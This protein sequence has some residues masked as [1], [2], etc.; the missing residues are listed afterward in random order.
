MHEFTMTQ[1]DLK[2][3][4]FIISDAAKTYS[5][6]AV[7]A[8]FKL[9]D[10]H[11]AS[12]NYLEAAISLCYISPER[13]C[14]YFRKS[15]KAFINSEEIDFA[16]Y[17][18]MLCGYMYGAKFS[19]DC[20]SIQFYKF[21]HRLRI[22]N[23]KDHKCIIK[24]KDLREIGKDNP[25]ELLKWQ[26]IIRSNNTIC[27]KKNKPLDL[28]LKCIYAHAKLDDDFDGYLYFQDQYK[29]SFKI[30]KPFSKITYVVKNRRG[31]RDEINYTPVSSDSGICI[32]T[33][34]KSS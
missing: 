19:D 11:R 20:L 16:I 6:A 14:V 24:D 22:Q 26:T 2:V 5:K 30:R 15:I 34:K 25:Q 4:L 7:L 33:Q 32:N 12:L 3:R 23:Q 17:L 9:I 27:K 10:Y 21:A 1:I 13:A 18:S 28:C 31:S 29:K 8:E